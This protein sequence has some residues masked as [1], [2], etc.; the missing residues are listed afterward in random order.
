MSRKVKESSDGQGVAAYELTGDQ[1]MVLFMLLEGKTQREA[2]AAVQVAEETVSRWMNH[3]P[4]FMAAYN[5]GVQSLYDAGL[6]ELLALRRKAIGVLG[7]KLERGPF[8]LKAAEL[9]LKHAPER[10]KGETIA[11][12]IAREQERAKLFDFGF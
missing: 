2:A 3:N 10:P 8:Q 9:V 5:A 1:N 12:E 6:N 4:G 11:E 7:E